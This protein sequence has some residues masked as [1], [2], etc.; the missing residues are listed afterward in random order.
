MRNGFDQF[1]ESLEA[2]LEELRQ[3]RME[4]LE[5]A[6]SASH[7]DHVTG[8]SADQWSV[9]EIVFHLHL[10]E[11]RTVAGLKRALESPLRPDRQARPDRPARPARLV[12]PDDASL[13][14]EWEKIRSV[15]GARAV[16]VN[17]PPRVEPVNAPL[18]VDAIKLIRQSR[19]ELLA[20][21][22]T[23]TFDELLVISMPHPFAAVGTLTG[24]GWLS[25]IAFHDLRHTAQ[26]RGMKA[27]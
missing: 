5:A 23:V 24:A 19:Q 12:R 10:A 15:I 27:S 14:A 8:T 22:Q 2:R 18:R 20:T 26:I 6:E 7:D 4:L 3:A 17:A 11:K 21:I 1:P 9:A 16:R 13:L 25:A